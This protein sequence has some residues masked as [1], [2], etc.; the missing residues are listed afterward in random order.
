MHIRINLVILTWSNTLPNDCFNSITYLVHGFQKLETNSFSSSSFSCTFM[1]ENIWSL[2]WTFL[3]RCTN[4]RCF[5]YFLPLALT[6]SCFHKN[7]FQ[8]Y[9]QCFDYSLLSAKIKVNWNVSKMSTGC[10]FCFS[11][12]WSCLFLPLFYCSS[13]TIANFFSTGLSR[14]QLKQMHVDQIYEFIQE[15]WKKNFW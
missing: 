7:L 14:H 11:S 2:I 3:W 6:T 8:H 13:G 15:F 10:E 9:C 4:L 12:T 5:N 1:W